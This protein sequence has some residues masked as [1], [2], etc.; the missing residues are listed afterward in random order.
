MNIQIS[1]EWHDGEVLMRY[2]E[3]L[4]RQMIN[5][6]K[7]RLAD[8]ML[9]IELEELQKKLYTRLNTTPKNKKIN[10]NLNTAT[11]TLILS[12]DRH[13]FLTDYYDE[14][15]FFILLGVLSKISTNVKKQVKKI[16]VTL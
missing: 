12:V 5:E 2:V 7:G 16:I 8:D 13:K 9:R 11:I 1:M 6:Y 14:P 15:N 4:I 3:V 10:V